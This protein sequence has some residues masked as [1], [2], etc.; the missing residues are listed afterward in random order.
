MGWRQRI[1][2]L[3]RR[4]GSAAEARRA[5]RWRNSAAPTIP[6]G[7]G[8]AHR[9]RTARVASRVSFTAMVR[10]TA[11]L[12]SRSVVRRAASHGAGRPA[13]APRS[14]FQ[15]IRCAIA[16]PT[17][18]VRTAAPHRTAA[19]MRSVSRNPAR[20]D[21][22]C[23]ARLATVGADENA[24]AGR[25][26]ARRRAR[27]DRAVSIRLAEL[28]RSGVAGAGQQSQSDQDRASHSIQVYAIAHRSGEASS[29][30]AK[31]ASSRIAVPSRLSTGCC[32]WTSTG[33]CSTAS[34]T[35]EERVGAQRST[36]RVICA[37][38]PMARSRSA[39]LDE[40][41]AI[42]SARS[43]RTCRYER[44]ASSRPMASPV[45]AAKS[46]RAA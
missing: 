38:R 34:A 17:A 18:P 6:V 3:L 12:P 36:E 13:S 33:G 8:P 16:R 1:W 9:N 26:I 10:R 7:R 42:A 23:S 15:A 37:P 5:Q 40:S 43:R 41:L 39:M 44:N 31:T 46:A 30:A 25:D 45:P 19:H 24:H 14:A 27:D 29:A 32:G 21:E 2:R 20:N 28:D 35:H 4:W 22:R 11:R